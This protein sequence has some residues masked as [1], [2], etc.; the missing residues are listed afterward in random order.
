MLQ[1][2]LKEKKCFLFVGVVFWRWGGDG[3][4]GWGKGGYKWDGVGAVLLL[5]TAEDRNSVE[6]SYLSYCSTP[7]IRI[8]TILPY[9]F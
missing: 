3:Y 1:T 7:G 9:L 4:V 5:F 6:P 8:L 2:E